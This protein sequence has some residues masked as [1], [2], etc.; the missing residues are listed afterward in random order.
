[1][2][3]FTIADL[4]LSTDS[5]TNKS[6]EVFGSRWKDYTSRLE[7]NWR[8]V[9]SD[10][11]TVVIPGDISWAL[12]LEEAKCDL[13]FLE[14]L[15]GKKILGKGNHDFWWTTMKK[16]ERFFEEA[17]IHSLSFLYNN[18]H[19][20]EDFII[21]GSRG[22][23]N[24]PDA[25]KSPNPSDFSKVTARELGRLKTSL[26]AARV[27]AGKSGKEI[28]AFTHF[29]PVWNGEA[30][31]E[32]VSLLL[33]YGVR[34]TYFGHIHGNYTVPPETEYRGIRFTL[35]SAD[36]LSFLPRVIRKD[37]EDKKEILS[38]T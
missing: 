32:I 13:L 34:R 17:G 10:G 27:L 26:D 2:S 6:M 18:A 8:A 20:T 25:V 19:E 14:S 11:D 35:I 28:L 12:T 21:A 7:T 31:E 22:W 29:P 24:D 15:P 3:L 33:S 37:T 4:H 16:H 36:Y 38:K 5:K 23:Y 9:V 1:M 30:S